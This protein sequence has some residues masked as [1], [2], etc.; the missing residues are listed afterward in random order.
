MGNISYNDRLSRNKS[1]VYFPWKMFNVHLTIIY[2]ITPSKSTARHL[3]LESEDDCYIKIMFLHS[4]MNMKNSSCAFDFQALKFW[5]HYLIYNP[6]YINIKYTYNCFNAVFLFHRFM[7]LT[8]GSH[9]L[10]CQRYRAGQNIPAVLYP[11]Y[12]TRCTVPA[13]LYP[14]NHKRNMGIKL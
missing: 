5:K 12:C 1:T 6:S 13:V 3:K 14:L 7:G 10:Q 11:L 8:V 9:W 4:L 2:T